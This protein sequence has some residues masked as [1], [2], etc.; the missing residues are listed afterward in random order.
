MFIECEVAQ[1]LMYRIAWLHEKGEL[2]KS[3]A[4]SSAAKLFCT[5]F[6]QHLAYG[7]LKIM[8]LY[9]QVK[10]GSKWAPLEGRFEQ[11]YHLCMGGNIAAGTSEIQKN[12]I[13]WTAL[14]L[15]RK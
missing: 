14:G 9:G 12:L 8:G 15:P 5:E 2:Q 7:G 3:M 4:P 10:E 13:A 6:N 1:S 11:T